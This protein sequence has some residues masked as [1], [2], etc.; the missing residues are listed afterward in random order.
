VMPISKDPVTSTYPRLVRLIYSAS[1]SSSLSVGDSFCSHL[2]LAGIADHLH[3]VCT[4]LILATEC[5]YVTKVGIL[6]ALGFPN[7]QLPC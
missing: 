1:E 2:I 4:N 6:T 5:P 7:R 3:P